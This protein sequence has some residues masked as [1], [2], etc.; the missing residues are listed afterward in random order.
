MAV[1]GF[2][3]GYV[4]ESFELT[5]MIFLGGVAVAMLICV[6]DWRLFR[7]PPLPWLPSGTTARPQQQMQLKK[8]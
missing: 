8:K 3:V 5:M 6:P 7:G 1:I 2:I 4:K